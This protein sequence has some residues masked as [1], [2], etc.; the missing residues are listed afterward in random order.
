MKELKEWKKFILDKEKEIKKRPFNDNAKNRVDYDFNTTYK[1]ALKEVLS[2]I[3]EIEEKY[4][5][6]KW[7]YKLN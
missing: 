3:E 6:T 1:Y 4:K 5:K 2:K 7:I